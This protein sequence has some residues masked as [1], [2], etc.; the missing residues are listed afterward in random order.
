MVGEGFH[1][2]VTQAVGSYDFC[3]PSEKQRNVGILLDGVHDALRGSC[4]FTFPVDGYCPSEDEEPG[5]VLAEMVRTAQKYLYYGRM[6]ALLAFQ[7][8]WAA[9]AAEIEKA[10]AKYDAVRWQNLA[11]KYASKARAALA[12]AQ[13]E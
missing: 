7:S 4:Y 11:A 2:V 12:T 5:E 8:W 9:N 13:G 6:E 10:Q 3:H 1:V